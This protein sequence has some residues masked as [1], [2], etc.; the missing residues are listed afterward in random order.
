MPIG[1]S[2]IGIRQNYVLVRSLSDLPSPVSGNIT[3]T[4]NTAYE[5]VGPINLGTNTITFGTSNLLFGIDKSDDKLIYTG[6]AAMF[7]NANKDFTIHTLTIQCSGLGQVFSCA[8]STNNIQIYNNIFAG[9][10]SIGSFVGGGLLAFNENL[11]GAN[12]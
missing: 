11:F 12:F 10:N 6:G 8:G 5:I 9:C 1:F 4:N 2:Q 7:N 3:L